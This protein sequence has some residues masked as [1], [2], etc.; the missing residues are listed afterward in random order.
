MSPEK[1]LPPYAITRAYAINPYVWGPLE[2]QI[3]TW[4]TN[5]IIN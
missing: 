1:F 4:F 3:N 5:N 2:N